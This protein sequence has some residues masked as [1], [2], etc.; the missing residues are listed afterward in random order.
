MAHGVG[1]SLYLGV[2][3]NGRDLVVQTKE[4][5]ITANVMDRVWKQW[6]NITE[7]GHKFG[8]EWSF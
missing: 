2:F 1:E 8:V 5:L 3:P 4:T 6:R 7:Q